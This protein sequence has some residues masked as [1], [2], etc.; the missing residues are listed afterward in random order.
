MWL[1]AAVAVIAVVRFSASV[2]SAKSVQ[3]F[4]QPLFT[5]QFAVR[6]PSGDPDTIAEKHGFINVGQCGQER[7][8]SRCAFWLSRNLIQCLSSSKARRERSAA[9]GTALPPFD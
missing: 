5:N 3:S 7:F 4:S 9:F 2:V 8:I 6:I 1:Y